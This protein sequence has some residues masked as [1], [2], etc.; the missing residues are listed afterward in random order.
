MKYEQIKYELKNSP[1]LK[2]LRSD[3]APLILSFFY[4]QF[5]VTQRISITQEELETKLGK[6]LEFLEEIDQDFKDRSPKEYLNKWCDDQLLRKTFNSS[7]D[8]VFTLTPAAEK[9]IAWLEDFKRREEDVKTFETFKEFA[10]TVTES[11]AE[12]LLYLTP[13]EQALYSYLSIH[14]Q[15]LEQE[16]I[17]QNYAY[18][19][20][21]SSCVRMLD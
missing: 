6:Y 5:K 21:H 12:N 16:R 4:N 8:P 2:L 20:I 19:Y 14:N 15:R 9:A 18:Q 1:T 17:S 7:D 11:I 13:E 3:N 10:V